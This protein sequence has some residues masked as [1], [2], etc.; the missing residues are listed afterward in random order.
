MIS[1]SKDTPYR[2]SVEL[3]LKLHSLIR[4][5]CGEG[6]EADEI[7]E[8]SEKP[9][10]Q[11]TEKEKQRLRCL[12]ADLSMLESDSGALH[13]ESG[14]VSS[15][16]ARQE[17][18]ALLLREDWEAVLQYLRDHPDRVAADFA[19]YYRGRCWDELGDHEAAVEFLRFAAA[20]NDLFASSLI[21]PLLSAGHVD[22]AMSLCERLAGSLEKV[23]NPYGVFAVA[24]GCCSIAG[25]ADEEH[26]RAWLERALRAF[27]EG[28]ARIDKLREQGYELEVTSANYASLALC[29]QLLGNADDARRTSETALSLDP[30]N[31]LA[32]I[33]HGLIL[34]QRLGPDITSEGAREIANGIWHGLADQA[35]SLLLEPSPLQP[36]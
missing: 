33:L 29:H 28:F 14:G 30:N 34:D 4:N 26:R 1:Q 22:E 20:K 9:W 35:H 3:L 36:A 13:P 24:N 12:S 19:A 2:Q 32:R 11:M 27:Q 8:A 23:L 7:R 25:R 16:D 6:E 31:S 17:L 5:G 18:E 15:D 10:W 21:S